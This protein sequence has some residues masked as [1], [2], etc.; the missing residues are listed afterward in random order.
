MHVFI[1]L[2]LQK[3]LFTEINKLKKKKSIHS[4]ACHACTLTYIDAISSFISCFVIPLNHG[5]HI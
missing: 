1:H 5:M 4:A 2:S 3:E